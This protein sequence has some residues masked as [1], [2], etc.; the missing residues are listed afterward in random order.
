MK[1]KIVKKMGRW[2]TY[3]WALSTNKGNYQNVGNKTFDSYE[4][5]EKYIKNL[6][7]TNG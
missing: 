7:A 4:D 6:G 2:G 3:H 5:A 1:I